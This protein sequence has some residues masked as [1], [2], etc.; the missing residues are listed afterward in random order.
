MKIGIGN[1]AR[2]F[3]SVWRVIVFTL[4]VCATTSAWAA[5]PV[6]VWDGSSSF[7]NFSTL[8][9]GDYTLNLN[10]QN[11]VSTDYS[12]V[13]IGSDNKKAGVTIT[14]GVAGAFGTAGEL[15]VIIV[16]DSLKHDY[17]N[18]AIIGLTK[19]D[20]NYSA[21]FNTDIKFAIATGYNGFSTYLKDGVYDGY[22][23][24]L[25][26]DGRHTM[27]LTYSS[28]TGGEGY[29]DG[30]RYALYSEVAES[31]FTSPSGVVLGGLDVDNSTKIYAQT[32]MKIYAVAIFNTKLT[33]EEIAAY[34]FPNEYTATVTANTAW[35]DIEWDGGAD[36]NDSNENTTVQLTVENDSVITLP[37]SL[38]AKTITINGGKLTTSSSPT[39]ITGELNGT[40]AIEVVADN[41]LTLNGPATHTG[42]TTINTGSKLELASSET[43]T[44]SSLVSGAGSVDVA[45]GTVTFSANSTY[46]GNLTVKSGAIAKAGGWKALGAEWSSSTTRRIVVENGGTFDVNGHATAYG[47]IIAGDGVDGE[48]ALKN[49]G[50]DCDESGARLRAL[51]LSADASIGGT[52]QFGLIG[53]VYAANTLNLNDHTLTKRGSARFNL[54]NTTINAG[55]GSA[56]RINISA[57]T[58]KW[59]KVTWNAEDVDFFTGSGTLELSDGISGNSANTYFKKASSFSG[60]V[61]V[62]KQSNY[63]VFSGSASFLNCSE[64]KAD[65]NFALDTKF[66]TTTFKINNLSGSGS[67]Q[68]DW[69]DSGVSATRTVETTQTKETTFS[70]VFNKDSANKRISGLV[71][72]GSNSGDGVLKLSGNNVTTG[73]LTVQNNAKVVLTSTGKWAGPVQV[74]DSGRLQVEST[75]A[76][77]GTVTLKGGAT[78]VLPKSV[79]LTA[80][81]VEIPSSG[82]LYVDLSAFGIADDAS[83]TIISATTLTGVENIGNLR[84][85]K[86]LYTFAVGEGGNTIEATNLSSCI[87]DGSSWNR[88]DPSLY[89][90]VTVNVAAGGTI[91]TLDDDYSFD[92]ITLSGSSGTLTIEANGHTLTVG[93]I[94]IPEGVTLTSSSALTITGVVS[95]DG[96]LVVEGENLSVYNAKTWTVSSVVV[97]GTLTLGGAKSII[98]GTVTGAG[99]IVYPT[100]AFPSVTGLNAAGW[101]GKVEIP[102]IAASSLLTFSLNSLGN[103][104]ST[105]VLKGI[106]PAPGGTYQAVYP[107]EA[108][109]GLAVNPT[110]QIDGYVSF[111]FGYS[112]W[113]ERLKYVTGS[114]DLRFDYY[115]S[116]SKWHIETL[117]GFSGSLGASVTYGVELSIGTLA[118]ASGTVPTTADRLVKISN[119]AGDNWAN[120]INVENTVVTVGGEATEYKLVKKN[121]GTATAGLYLAP[122]VIKNGSTLTPYDSVSAA[123]SAIGPYTTY[124]YVIVNESATISQNTMSLKLKKGFESVVLTVNTAYSEYTPVPA[125]SSGVIT[126]T[127]TP[128]KTTYTWASTLESGVWNTIDP[129]P[130][131]YGASVEANRAPSTCDDIQFATDAIITV[132]EDISVYSIANSA[133]VEFSTT[134]TPTVAANAEGGIVLTAAGASFTVPVGMTLSPTPTTSVADYVVATTGG[135]ESPTVYTAVL[136]AA[137]VGGTAYATLQAAIDAAGENAVTLLQDNSESITIAA[138]RTLNVEKGGFT[139]NVPTSTGCIDVQS[140]YNDGTGITTYTAPV[141]AIISTSSTSYYMSISQA[142]LMT[143][144]TLLDADETATLTIDESVALDQDTRTYLAV[145]YDIYF[146][147]TTTY[148]KAVAKR[149]YPTF[150]T[151]NSLASAISDSTDEALIALVRDSDEAI[152]LNKSITLTE[153]ATFTGT[154]SGSGTLTLSALRT[155][156]ITF[157]DWD[158]VV[159]LPSG[160]T[161]GGGQLDWYGKEGSTV[162][163]QGS[164]SGWFNYGKV[165]E[166][167]DRAPV[168]TTVDIPAGASLTI[169][170]W[171]PAFANTIN[172]LTG[173]GA[174]NVSITGEIDLNNNQ[175]SAYFLLKNVSGFTGSLSATGAG[176]AIGD[177]KPAYATTGGKVIV[178]SGKTATVGASSTWTATNI[179]V[180]GAVDV[181][182]GGSMSGAIEGNGTITYATIPT[183]ALSFGTWTGTVV[184]PAFNAGA[185]FDFRKYGIS[186][187][188]VEIGGFASGWLTPYG[189]NN[190]TIAV[191][192]NLILNGDMSLTAMSTRV[193]SFQTISGTGSF[194]VSGKQ[195]TSMS[196]A[197]IGA[198]YEGTISN[199]SGKDLT[200]TAVDMATVPAVGDRLLKVSGDN[201]TIS[202]VTVNGV[203]TPLRWVRKTVDGVDGFY[204]ISGTIFSVW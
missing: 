140:D 40:V 181:V 81:G 68:P 154:L 102:S 143:F 73:Q 195:H 112:A 28:E 177:S 141:A 56:G 16:C 148:S 134:A 29:F 13:Q 150:A 26:Y 161:F 130:W 137:R 30:S 43:Y 39:S 105:V 22:G 42:A 98:S 44:Y 90:D 168:V 65:G 7:C 197:K 17:S 119:A 145:Q 117:T 74:E 83:A 166:T 175:H 50:A 194:S 189:D 19:E 10:S 158:G 1:W 159:V 155:S 204:V 34:K 190:T 157:G 169:T 172:V 187:S 62:V 156:A 18:R 78:V 103:T 133:N 38:T 79:P 46:T 2:P 49:T 131:R 47:Y 118:L 60:I 14:S 106:D 70:G 4:V 128:T 23:A 95:G 77:G 192:P 75:A 203:A 110:L 170:G 113:A 61:R 91:L 116:A 126:Y 125:E 31:S 86:G 33:A 12:Y 138:G 51:E 180:D 135:E 25:S 160:A 139:C 94:V 152:T 107:S 80:T 153:S 69:G 174:F 171:S 55:S 64:F 72:N 165:G 52:G 179:K 82:T 115:D 76:L 85:T 54:H 99:K 57:G 9:K 11:T 100:G 196:I 36:W 48:G 146:D 176:I 21:N 120:I 129:S 144:L 200:I 173:A 147:G 59:G 24:T 111:T 89:S 63:P 142:E 186:G 5:T 37:N 121:A 178:T 183:S 96:C 20:G 58:I 66:K 71:V 193:Y 108:A 185:G 163:V 15:T 132:Y 32:G 87:W 188:T 127:L 41:T 53:G 122:A 191:A 184:L 8:T 199:T 202:G 92:T 149:T 109:I 27:A 151:F 84:S 93:D 198:G 167:P 182:S 164:T 201:I 67:I 45:A 101:T 104:G 88:A 136:G 97:N 162:R 35:E 3:A 123:I 114:G 124:D 6:V